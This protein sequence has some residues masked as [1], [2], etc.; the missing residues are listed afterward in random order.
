MLSVG[1][2]TAATGNPLLVDAVKSIDEQ[3]YDYWHHYLFYDG[4]ISYET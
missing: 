4:V 1:I 3:S 2:I